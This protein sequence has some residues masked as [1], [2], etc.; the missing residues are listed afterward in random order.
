MPR[1]EFLGGQFTEGQFD[2]GPNCP[3]PIPIYA[4]Y[5]LIQDRIG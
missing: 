4:M 1:A 3:V 2:K 5:T